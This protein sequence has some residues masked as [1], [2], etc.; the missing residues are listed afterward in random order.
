[1]KKEDCHLI[2]RP[3]VRT[4]SGE[5]VEHEL[6]LNPPIIVGFGELPPLA[7]MNGEDASVTL[8]MVATLTED[9]KAVTFKFKGQSEGELSRVHASLPLGKTLL[10]SLGSHVVESRSEQS[11]PILNK[12]PYA[13]RL[14]KNT[15]VA[16]Q[17]WH[18]LLYVTCRKAERI[19]PWKPVQN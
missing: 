1:M 7:H 4:L 17:T 15:G 8:A 9:G 2:L 12:V 14:F 10:T 18:R 11:V 5:K 19:P 13:S 16:R 3:N 6:D